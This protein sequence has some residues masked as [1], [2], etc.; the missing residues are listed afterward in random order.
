MNF[1]HRYLEGFSGPEDIAITPDGTYLLVSALPADFVNPDGPALMQVELASDRTSPIPIHR[2]PEPGWGDPDSDAPAQ[3]GTHGLHVSTRP[4]GRIQLLAVNHA[5]RESV[6]MFEL[7]RGSSGYEAW[8]RGS[9]AFD[10]GLLNDVV[11]TPEGGFIAT[12]MLDHA[13]LGDRDAMTVLFSGERIG[14]L[15]E[16]HARTGWRRL[17]G[18]EAALNNGI[19][20]GADGRLVWF[21][22]WTSG[23]VHEY[24]RER[25]CI[26]RT[27]TLPFYADNLTLDDRGALIATGID[28]L[29]DWRARTAAQGRISRDKLPFS[30][31]RIEPSTFDAT[32]LFRGGPG[33]LEGGASVALLAG[34][35]LYVGSYAGDRLLKIESA[36]HRT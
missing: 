4:D 33:L 36:G 6:E 10:G 17:P 23:E 16:W 35:A 29:D 22:A 27:A 1:P 20:I 2:E 28:D 31:A 14:Y 13:L 19:Q 15:A 21:A 3:F 7:V 11:A 8:W 26:T 12:V 9:V 34:D 25:Q 24:D 30:I 32:P 5:E 18:S